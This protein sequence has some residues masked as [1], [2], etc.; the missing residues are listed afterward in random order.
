MK[1]NSKMAAPNLDSMSGMST[2]KAW[3][4][5]APAPAPA[6]TRGTCHV[7]LRGGSFDEGEM[8]SER[9][10]GAKKGFGGFGKSKSAKTR[11][12]GGG[13]PRLMAAKSSAVEDEHE[14]LTSV[15]ATTVTVEEDV[16]SHEQVRRCMKK[17]AA[18]KT[19]F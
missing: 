19:A 12:R 16:I 14:M 18:R 7:L 1:H 15:S 4:E 6:P 5:S 13:G 3:R 17:S 2:L 9:K 10:R 11:S 8:L